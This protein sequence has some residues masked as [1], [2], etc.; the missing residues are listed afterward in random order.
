MNK[1]M[2]LA[3]SLAA[4]AATGGL[5]TRGNAQVAATPMVKLVF[6]L[7]RRPGMEPEE[8]SR[9]WRDVHGPIGA[10]MPGVRK[11]VQNHARATLDASPLPCDGF[12]ELWFDDMASLER[13][14]ASPEG[15]AALTDS[16][17]FLDVERIQTFVVEEVP[18]A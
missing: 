3:S 4:A 11:Y 6:L 9:Y 13:S 8:F 17:K 15:Q 7:H 18:V 14:L 12:A 1:R 2:F 10:R 16:E 5:N